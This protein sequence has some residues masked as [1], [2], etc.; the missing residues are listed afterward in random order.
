MRFV[1]MGCFLVGS[2]SF[3]ALIAMV[4][5]GAQKVRSGHGLDTYRTAWIVELNGTAFVILLAVTGVAWSFA[6]FLRYREW[7]EIKQRQDDG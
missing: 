3:G 1:R 4:V 5:F 2:A 6:E 7:R